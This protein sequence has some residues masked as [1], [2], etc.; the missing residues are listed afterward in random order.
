M[1]SS[2]LRELFLKYFEE[3]G[4]AV[5]PSAS[6]VPEDVAEADKTLFTSAGMQQFKRFYTDPDQTPYSKVATC[7][8][9][10]RTIDIDEVGDDT[11]LTFFEMLGNFSFGYP[12]KKQSYFK[13]DAIKY[14]W[15]FLTEI[16]K[17][18]KERIHATYFNGE[19]IEGIEADSESKELIKKIT[20]LGDDKIIGQPAEDNFWSLGSEGS[21]GG[22]TVEFYIDG[23]EIWNLVFNEYTFKE[24]KYIPSE[25]KGVDTGMGL[26]R[27]LTTLNGH[28]NVYETDLF[29]PMIE[30]IEEFSRKKFVENKREFRIIADHIKTAV[31]MSSGKII[32]SNIGQGY[33]MRRL[34]R[35]AIRYGKLINIS[36]I[37]GLIAPVLSIYHSTYPEF[38]SER[39]IVDCI[40]AEEKKFEQT[41]EEGLRTAKRIFTSKKPIVKEKFGKIMADANKQ[42]L[43]GRVL[44]NKR[45]NKPYA[46][47]EPNISENEVNGA[48]ISGEEAFLLYQ[49]YGFPLELVD[50]LAMNEGF[51]VDH[52]GFREELTK[53]QELSR[54]ASAGMFK[55]GLADAGDATTKYHTATHLLLAALQKLLDENIIQRGSNITS[56]RMRFDFNYPEKMTPEQIKSVEDLVNRQIKAELP[57]VMEEMSLDEAKAAGAKG[58]FEHKYGEKVKVYTIGDK[59]APFSKEVCGGP[60]VENTKDLGHFKIQ[61]EES[62]SAG[63]RR[64]KAVLE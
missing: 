6:L 15:E 41:L 40:A 62:S 7:Q 60:H 16:L 31:F 48:I 64:I 13:E 54:T 58:V 17:V 12:A 53:H 37:V 4:H 52:Y 59:N 30:K 23:I 26:E 29:L 34:I 21:P 20:N 19:G 3:K 18:N 24:G 51:F 56:E 45:N 8:K 32:P 25:F 42:L 10:I 36:T 57:V 43:I 14:A 38:A 44:E 39:L 47:K 63:V 50:E 11:H 28:N 2:E 5:L 46:L 35:R 9:C 22:P 49:S 33:V 1:K 27:L 61:K 55:G